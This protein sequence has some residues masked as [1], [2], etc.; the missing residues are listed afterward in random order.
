MILYFFG[1]FLYFY[2]SF[3]FKVFLV[4]MDLKMGT[5]KIAA[6]TGHAGIL[7]I[8]KMELLMFL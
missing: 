7:D 3:F 4:R 8:S 2:Y 6:Q 1:N 5:G